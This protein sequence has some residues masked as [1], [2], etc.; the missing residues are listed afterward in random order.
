VSN[1]LFIASPLHDLTSTKKVFQWGG[2]EKK[3]FETLK[4]NINIALLLTF[5]YLQQP[6]EI[7]IDTS[8]YAITT[9][10]I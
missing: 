5:L 2:K 6:F 9:V 7:E 10:I 3:S 8:D 1:F 4:E